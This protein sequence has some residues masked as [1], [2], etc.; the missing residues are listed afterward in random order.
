[1]PKVSAIRLALLCLLL[2][3]AVL[4]AAVGSADV[5]ITMKVPSGSYMKTCN[6]CSLT[7]GTYTCQCKNER[8]SYGSTSIDLGTCKKDKNGF[9]Q[10]TNLNGVLTCS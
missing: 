10:L 5:E 2:L 6:K 4:S 3:T 7:G 1:M 8:G 9:Y